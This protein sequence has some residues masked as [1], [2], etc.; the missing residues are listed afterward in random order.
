ML[1]FGTAVVPA[2]TI[3]DTARDND[4]RRVQAFVAKDFARLSFIRW[5][6]TIVRK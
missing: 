6:Y 2:A 5:S 3:A 1:V 4:L